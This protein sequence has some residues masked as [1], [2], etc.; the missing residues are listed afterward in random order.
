MCFLIEYG[1][2]LALARAYGLDCDLVYQ[3]QWRNAPAS[4]ATIHDY[5]SKVS[6]RDWV[7]RECLGRVPDDVDA[8]RELLTY[9]LKN[10]DAAI[11]AGGTIADVTKWKSL[12]YDETEEELRLKEETHRREWLTKIDFNNLTVEQK[13][14]I[15]TR[16][17]LLQYLDRLSIYEVILGGA[18]LA[19]ERFSSSFF[20]KFRSQSAL[21]STIQFAHQG[22]WQAVVIMF[23]FNGA[24]TLPHRL[25]VCS[26]FPETLAPF[27]YRSVLPECDINGEVF[28]WDQESLRE[29]DWSESPAVKMA[30]DTELAIE[31]ESVEAFYEEEP[32]LKPFRSID[33]DLNTHLVSEWY[34]F[35]SADIERQ[36]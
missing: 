24:Q 11:V 23:T 21:Q 31:N 13:V 36:R 33:V 18:H 20:E 3:R 35:R 25:T 28:L 19:P 1:E 7:L 32:K 10:T 8:V 34:K 6:K 29:P 2:A 17:R 22:D 16:R 4:V 14:L 27:D 30:V 5:L 26:S 9:G 12:D 15:S